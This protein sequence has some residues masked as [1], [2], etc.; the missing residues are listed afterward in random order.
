MASIE[1]RLTPSVTFPGNVEDVKTAVRWLRANAGRLA[2]EH[3]SHRDLGHIGRR[4]SRRGRRVVASRHV[5]RCGQP[6]SIE[7]GAVRAR[8]LRSRD[9]HR[10]G[11]AD[12]KRKGHAPA[13]A[14]G[15]VNAPPMVGG[16]V[17]TSAAGESWYCRASGRRAGGRPGRDAPRRANSPESRLVGAPIQTVPDRVKAASPL[18]YVQPVRRRFS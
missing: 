13:T 10:D 16:V 2:L 18:T 8:R 14:P 12:R 3:G 11:R 6:R 7:R 17:T 15:L 4:A 5:R 1:Y 9:V